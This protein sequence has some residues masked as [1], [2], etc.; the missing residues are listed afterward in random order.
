[1]SFV[2]SKLFLMRRAIK[3]A[4]SSVV[5][6]SL[7]GCAVFEILLIPFERE[8]QWGGAIIEI[9]KLALPSPSATASYGIVDRNGKI[10]V[11][12]QAD[13]ISDYRE[14]FSATAKCND[15]GKECKYGFRDKDLNWV[16][17]PNLDQRPGDFS[18]GLAPYPSRSYSFGKESKYLDKTGKFAFGG[19]G[20]LQAGDFRLGYA[21]IALKEVGMDDKRRVTYMWGWLDKQG[22]V[23]DFDEPPMTLV[24]QPNTIMIREGMVPCPA[25]DDQN[26]MKWGFKNLAGNWVIPPKYYSV[27]PFYFGKAFVQ[28]ERGLDLNVFVLDQFHLIDSKG[29]QV[30]PDAIFQNVSSPNHRGLGILNYVPEP[31]KQSSKSYLYNWKTEKRSDFTVSSASN[32]APVHWE[33][34]WFN[35]GIWEKDSDGITRFRTIFYDENFNP[36]LSQTKEGYRMSRA[37]SFSEDTAFIE[38]YRAHDPKMETKKGFMDRTGKILFYF[39]DKLFINPPPYVSSGRIRMYHVK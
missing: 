32:S 5:L 18:E 21:R 12:M 1:M 23:Y 19:K 13:W 14:G 10:I 11:P 24:N 25:L 28:V 37:E 3:V 35:G 8:L 20:F 33:D 2:V 29:N 22:K 34:K 36:V 16:I 9:T 6:F 38:F 17:P 39:D 31:G 26:Q 7:S 27:H 4:W 30:L 15:K